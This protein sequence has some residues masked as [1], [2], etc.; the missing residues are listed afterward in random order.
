VID[1]SNTEVLLSS[2][3]ETKAVSL[4]VCEWLSEKVREIMVYV[5]RSPRSI[6]MGRTR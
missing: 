1:I 4:L 6:I 3:N 2:E 5:T